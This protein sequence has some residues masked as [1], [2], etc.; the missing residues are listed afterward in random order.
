MKIRKYLVTAISTIYTPLFYF[1]E[2]LA[3]LAVYDKASRLEKLNTLRMVYPNLKK[4]KNR[5]KYGPMNILHKYYLIEAEL[6]RV[7][8]KDKKAEDYY[9]KAVSE[10]SKN[11]YINEEAL[12]SERA[13]VYH[14]GRENQRI[15]LTYLIH[16]RQCYERWGA[17]V[18]VKQM[19]EMYPELEK[20]LKTKIKP[21]MSKTYMSKTNTATNIQ[22]RD[23]LDL[24]AIIKASQAIS[25]EIVYK[26]LIDKLMKTI[27]ES[28]GA[29]SILLLTKKEDNFVIEANYSVNSTTKSGFPA[30]I[31]N[32]VE[33]TKELLI[34]DDVSQKPDFKNDKYKRK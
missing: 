22:N 28:A 12:A 10:A 19:D 3:Y 5:A 24:V 30:S 23:T 7:L 32:F 2:S 6:A 21:S 4:L 27:V 31:I 11:E 16:A 18:K 17:L 13:G 25:G 34:L 14:L 29:E 9:E 20:S 33:R 8:G 26:N 1:Y 15:A